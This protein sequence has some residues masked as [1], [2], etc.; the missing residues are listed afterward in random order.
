[1]SDLDIRW[2]QRFVNYNKA[3]AQ[4]T[5]FIEQ[6][7]LNELE[8]Q[9]LIHA[10]EYTFELA[11]NLIKD[12]YFYQGETEIQGSRDAFRIAFSRNLIQDGESWMKMIESRSRTSHT[13]NEETAREI[14][15]A[16][17]NKYFDMFIDLQETFT[18]LNDGKSS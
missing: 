12:Y 3:L 4:L 8:E 7:S 2:K 15:D 1:M 9:G 13:Y 18:N 14:A 16:I 17:R 5:K 6:L 11:W 10:F